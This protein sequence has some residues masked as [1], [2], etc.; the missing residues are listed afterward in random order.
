MHSID[1]RISVKGFA[2]G[3]DATYDIVKCLATESAAD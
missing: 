1:E 2:E 3:L